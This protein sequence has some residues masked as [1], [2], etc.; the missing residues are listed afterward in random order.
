MYAAS[1][2]ATCYTNTRAC[3][4]DPINRRLNGRC[5]RDDEERGRAGR[6]RS[7]PIVAG[8]ESHRRP[9]R[10]AG[11]GKPWRWCRHDNNNNSCRCGGEEGGW[12]PRHWPRD[13]PWCGD[14]NVRV[15]VFQNRE[16][17]A[18]L[19]YL[20]LDYAPCSE[21]VHTA[22][23]DTLLAGAFC[24]KHR[25]I[26]CMYDIVLL[27]LQFP[28]WIRCDKNGLQSLLPLH[29]PVLIFSPGMAE[30]RCL[31]Y[32]TEEYSSGVCFSTSKPHCSRFGDKMTLTPS[33][34]IPRK[35]RGS[36]RV[37]MTFSSLFHTSTSSTPR[38]RADSSSYKDSSSVVNQK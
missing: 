1:P 33:K 13:R 34:Y 15:D 3:I 31:I 18:G 25:G 19:N 30:G 29:Q 20:Q 24:V 10:Q 22:L 6:S 27:C 9:E 14:A 5:Y 38:I 23:S 11:C 21:D 12:R 28:V 36:N 16:Y 35:D 26:K 17:R 32:N 37:I 4:A 8:K 2:L 7:A